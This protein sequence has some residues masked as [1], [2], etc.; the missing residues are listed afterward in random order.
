MR[1]LKPHWVTHGKTSKT[2]PF[3]RPIYTLDIHPDGKRLATGGLTDGGGLIILWDMSLIRDPSLEK[4]STC[5]RLFQMDN[6]QACVNCVRWSPT[7]RWLASGGMDR[8]VMVWVKTSAGARAS[9][10]FGA[11]EKMKFTE[12][13]R[14]ATVLRHHTGDIIDIA[15]AQDGLRL[16]SCSVDN[17]VVIW[18]PSQ[19]T[20][21]NASASPFQ[22]I[23]TLRGHGGPVKGVAWDPA[24]RYLATQAEGLGVRVWRVSDWQ[25]ESK[26]SKP[27][28]KAADQSQ[29]TRLSWSPDGSVIVA[30][31]AINNRFPT[32]Q[33][34][35]RNHW[36]PGLDLVGHEKHVVCAR[37]N[38]NL[39]RKSTAT[40][41]S[42]MICLALGSKDRSVSVWTT[43][44]RRAFL[45]IRDL[46]T[47]SVSD[48]TWSSDGKELLA[49]SLDGS[50]SYMAFTSEEIGE[51]LQVSEV[52]RIHRKTYGQS[53]LDTLSSDGLSANSTLP[54]TGEGPQ[55]VTKVGATGVAGAAS[56]PV[57]LETPEALALQRSQAE[58]RVRLDGLKSCETTASSNG[59][60]E[61]PVQPTSQTEV[62][63][64]DGRRRITPR[65]LGTLDS[66]DE[67]PQANSN[68]Q[69]STEKRR[70]SPTDLKD[71]LMC[72]SNTQGSNVSSSAVEAEIHKDQPRPQT[73]P[74][75]VAV[76][77]KPLSQEVTDNNP[78]PS[79]VAPVVSSTPSATKASPVRP[80]SPTTATGASESTSPSFSGRKRKRS[81]VVASPT[82]E[83]GS[84]R[85]LDK[86]QKRKRRRHRLF[87]HDEATASAPSASAA[88]STG[89]GVSSCR[90]QSTKPVTPDKE[91]AKATSPAQPLH[92]TTGTMQM[93]RICLEQMPTVGRTQ[94]VCS[95][96]VEGTVIVNVINTATTEGSKSQSTSMHKVTASRG[97]KQIW[98][99]SNRDRFTAHA[100]TET[101]IALGDCRGRLRLLQCGG[102]AICPPIIVESGLLQ[103][104]AY[105]PWK[106][107]TKPNGEAFKPAPGARPAFSSY[108]Y[109]L[110]EGSSGNQ[111]SV[112]TPAASSS[113][114]PQQQLADLDEV[115]LAAI[116]ATGCL[117]VWSLFAGCDRTPL[118]SG[119]L[120]AA[121]PQLLVEST[122]AGIVQP[123]DGGVCSSLEFT[124]KGHLVVRLVCGSCYL[125]NT[126]LRVWVELLDALDPVKCH[127]AISMQRSCPSGPLCNLQH[128]SK[129]TPPK[130]AG[131]PLDRIGQLSGAQR[132]SLSEFL[133]CQMQGAELVGSSAE[134]KFWLL[135]WFRHLV[136]DGED[137]RIRQVC[138]EFIGPFVHPS[139]TSWQP[140][141]KGISKRSLVKELLAL[142]A[143]NLRMQRLYVELKELLEQSQEN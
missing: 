57:L 72:S 10:I 142:F 20:P 91:T 128:I 24:G 40:G 38:P 62:R 28:V 99:L 21:N 63:T 104:A 125:F 95:N 68:S 131:L 139:R 15:W 67:E 14:C 81:E 78:S 41:H 98:E 97:D 111:A 17:T 58:L 116:T 86:A 117:R 114:Q 136:E 71:N 108:L 30:P 106:K 7:G 29:V 107:S 100:H 102:A 93:S 113:Y 92:A 90:S 9:A 22:C 124:D 13:W 35:N 112:D 25:E 105:D 96:S 135:R 73:D 16:A 64:K 45:V 1:L 85:P 121:L 133:E 123:G 87:L 48:L 84:E 140:T 61:K 109:P 51:P 141:I 36:H 132:Q 34:I 2:G 46:F 143:L 56:A 94:F 69:F 120:S 33:L 126:E 65:F 137:E 60:A 134:F 101:L 27:F 42:V 54:L 118:L 53:L 77:L 138:M 23:A 44:G 11:T 129:L 31:H 12:H 89:G 50:V 18:G 19:G 74:E 83:A 66:L 49:C 75:T 82:Q 3:L 52:A 110:G 4:S 76:V 80:Q 47:N 6:H 115:R 130:T 119:R 88:S 55:G 122:V 32:A 79:H 37:Y 59:S 39:L 127:A 5:Q 26:I 103:L 43:L 8:V 70:S